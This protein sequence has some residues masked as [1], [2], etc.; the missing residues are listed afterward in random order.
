M[1]ERAEGRVLAL[2]AGSSSLKFELFEQS[3]A[4]RSRLRGVVREIGRS[5]PTLRLQG[6][7]SERNVR[8][9][10]HAEAAELV[11]DEI[12]EGTRDGADR[13]AVVGHRIVHGAALFDS[14]V[15]VTDGVIGKLHSLAPLAPLHNPPALS[16]LEIAR[17]RLS[18]AQMV[19][20]FDTAF[21]REMPDHAK[22]YAVPERWYANHGVQRFGFHGL[23][24]AY[25]RDRVRRLYGAAG[26]PRRLVSLHLG[27]GC[28]ATAFENGCPIETSMGFTPLEGLVMGTRSGDVDAGAILHMARQGNSW[29]ALESE[30]NGESGLLGLSGA[31]D[32][33]RELLTLE[34]SGHAGA[35]LA[36]RVFCHRVR[37]CIGAYAAA[38]GGLDAL[39]FGGG[40]GENAPRIRARICAGFEWLG[41]ELDDEANDRCVGSECRISG[42]DSS[43]GVDVVP[44]REEEAIARAALACAETSGAVGES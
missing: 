5:R 12:L 11:L 43:V 7:G 31:S 30:L 20:V 14:P 16:V 34:E 23:A 8:T 22:R 17:S 25:L 18:D 24:H 32:D 39:A 29:Q 15:L 44:V 42:T 33:V 40:V 2:N 13:I 9:A 28:S 37:K 10:T 36:L 27:Q 38:L 26:L 4:W 19:A 35:Q 3:P 1:A 6:G 41:L 21:F